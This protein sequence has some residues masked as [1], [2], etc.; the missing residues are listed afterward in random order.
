M[1]SVY[2][3]VKIVTAVRPSVV[4]STGTPVAAAISACDTQGYNTGM[5]HVAVGSATGTAIT[6]VVS[7]Q[8]Q[9]CATSNGTF[10][11]ISGATGTVTGTTTAA[12]LACD[13]RIEG[14]GTSRQRYLKV[15][16]LVTPSAAGHD[17]PVSAEFILARGF[18]VP[19]G[20][21]A[22]VSG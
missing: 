17:I 5:L 11:D 18:K 10:T 8:V 9:E 2:D 21:S 4:T 16:P 15:T 13:I 20:N 1:R 14:L 12:G 6:Y 19:V 7:I 3:N 22:S